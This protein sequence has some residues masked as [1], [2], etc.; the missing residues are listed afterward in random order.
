MLLQGVDINNKDVDGIRAVVVKNE[1]KDGESLGAGYCSK[2]LP[3]VTNV[4]S[5]FEQFFGHF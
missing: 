3:N 2:S 5:F 4:V 1:V